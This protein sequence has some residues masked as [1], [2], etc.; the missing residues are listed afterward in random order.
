M[1]R[2][3]SGWYRGHAP[4]CEDH[5]VIDAAKEAPLGWGFW[6]A[7]GWRWQGRHHYAELRVDRTAGRTI[8]TAGLTIEYTGYDDAGRCG[9]VV[10]I[11]RAAI[12]QQPVGFGGVRLWICCP[13]C[14][15]RCRVLYGGQRLRCRKCLGLQ[16]WCQM[17]QPHDR[18]YR[19]AEKVMRRCDPRAR[20]GQDFPDKPPW[21]RWD[22]YDRLATQHEFLETIGILSGL[23]G[24]LGML[25]SD[26]A[27]ARGAYRAWR[28]EQ[29]KR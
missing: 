28:A 10:A 7:K 16:Y 14:G 8:A 29:R 19:Q 6:T 26:A 17:L 27:E 24:R 2:S 23:P 15:R 4:R 5:A 12:V 21:M 18:A 22:T 20:W 11:E 25:N 3:R 9:R 1:G 13:G